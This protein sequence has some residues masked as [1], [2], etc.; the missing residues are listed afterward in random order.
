M[1]NVV[2]R[3]TELASSVTQSASKPPFGSPGEREM[4]DVPVRVWRETFMACWEAAMVAL[5]SLG[6][7]EVANVLGSS[8]A[9]ALNKEEKGNTA[10][11]G[12][13]AERIFPSWHGRVIF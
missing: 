5:E 13:D 7:Q 2:M 10:F 11:S 8:Q 9:G 3:F 1:A 12:Y 4:G 6:A